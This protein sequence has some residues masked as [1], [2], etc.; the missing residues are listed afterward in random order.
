MNGRSARDRASTAPRLGGLLEAAVYGSDLVALERFYVDVF[1]MEP[2]A[3][4]EGRH[5]MLRCSHS[6]V[7]LFD[8]DVSERAGGTVPPHGARGPGHI[9]LVT[10][11]PDV[12]RWREHFH[13]CGVDIEREVEWPHAGTSLYVRDPAGNSIEVAPASLWNGIGRDLLRP[14]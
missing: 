2:I 11:D 5:T 14:E 4:M 1:G 13:A 3:R 7:I 8:P 9:A 10:A 6:V 12:A